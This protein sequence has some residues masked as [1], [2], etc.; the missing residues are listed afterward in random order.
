MVGLTLPYRDGEPV[1]LAELGVVCDAV[2]GN[3][4]AG[5]DVALPEVGHWV[6]ARLVQQH[7][8]VAV[9]DPLVAEPHP[10]PAP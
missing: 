1:H 6:A 7:D 5:V 2:F 10:H 4:D 9:G 3:Q 8:V